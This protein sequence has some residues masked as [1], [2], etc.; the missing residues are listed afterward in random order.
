MNQNPF[1]APLSKSEEK[2]V[3]SSYSL[4][5]TLRAYEVEEINGLQFAQMLPEIQGGAECLEKME[6]SS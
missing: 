2:S 4:A 5:N 3:D 6:T 1:A